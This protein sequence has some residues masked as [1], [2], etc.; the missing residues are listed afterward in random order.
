VGGRPPHPPLSA[1]PTVALFTELR[2]G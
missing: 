1:A 2:Y